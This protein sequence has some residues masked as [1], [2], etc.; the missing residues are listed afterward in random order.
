MSSLLAS[1]RVPPVEKALA[2]PVTA[3]VWA[4]LLRGAAAAA[5]AAAGTGTDTDTDTAAA[6]TQF[7]QVR[8]A[9]R[10][11][12]SPA[13]E[14][15]LGDTDDEFMDMLLRACLPSLS[16]LQVLLVP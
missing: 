10:L 16:P 6:A 8:A 5:A 7:V 15:L 1:A 11:H 4:R 13:V 9:F 2:F 14:L 12:C 3:P